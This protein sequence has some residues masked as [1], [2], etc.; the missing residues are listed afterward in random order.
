MDVI[1]MPQRRAADVLIATNVKNRKRNANA[2]FLLCEGKVDFASHRVCVDRGFSQPPSP[3]T[4]IARVLQKIADV[5]HRQR[6]ESNGRAFH[7]LLGE[8]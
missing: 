6:N 1:D 2:A 7:D 8:C 5:L 3:K 4:L